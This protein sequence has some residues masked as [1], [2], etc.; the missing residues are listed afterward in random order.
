M[1][2][3]FF[4]KEIYRIGKRL[5]DLRLF[6]ETQSLNST[7]MQMVREIIAAKETGNRVISSQ[8]AKKLGV[9]RS[10]VSQMVHK[11]EKNNIVR[12][13]PDVKDKK[14]AYIELSEFARGI[15]EQMK[16]KFAFFLDR[17]TE[18]LGEQRMEEFLDRA[19]EFLDACE[20]VSGSISG[21]EARL[22]ENG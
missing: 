3:T 5:G 4:L 18:K 19:N 15:Y 17:V 8:L 6:E 2:V 22:H 9:T 10:A 11:L 13:V 1:E 21:R 12:R 7:E 14:I 20:S 16:Q